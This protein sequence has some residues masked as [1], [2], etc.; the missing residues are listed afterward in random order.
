MPKLTSLLLSQSHSTVPKAPRK[1]Q[2]EFVD[3][4]AVYI[5]LI[6]PR[7]A[8]NQQDGT[9]FDSNSAALMISQSNAMWRRRLR[10]HQYCMWYYPQVAPC[11]L[12]GLYQRAQFPTLERPL[13]H[14]HRQTLSKPSWGVMAMKRSE[15]G[16][17][18][19]TESSPYDY[20][21]YLQ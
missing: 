6:Y 5:R 21:P 8:I 10:R 12:I 4:P 20:A 2:S 9:A 14:S 1:L 16:C 7:F 18:G 17:A 19:W 11:K 3:N 15:R 13:H